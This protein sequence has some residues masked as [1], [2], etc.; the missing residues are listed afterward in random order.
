MKLA[1]DAALNSG[2]ITWNNGTMRSASVAARTISNPVTLGTGG[3]KFVAGAGEFTFTGPVT[4]AGA[5]PTFFGV[6]TGSNATF[7]DTVSESDGS[8]LVKGGGG[9]LV[10]SG[11]NSY[12]GG[13]NI[14]DGWL[15]VGADGNLGASGTSISFGS[16]GTL[17]AS[18]GTLLLTGSISNARDIVVFED[19]GSVDSNGSAVTTTGTV[20]GPGTLTKTGNGLLNVANVRTGGLDVKVGTVSVTANGGDSG[21]SQIG[22]LTINGGPGAPT[23]TFNLSD[24]D[25]IFTAT[26]QADIQSL[27][28][29]ARNGGTWGQ[30]GVNSSAAAAASPK[31]TGL[32]VLTGAEYTSVSGSGTFNGLAINSTDVLVKYTYYGDT[33]FNGTVNF[34]D[35]SRTDA[36]FNNNRS[37]WLNGD[38]DG[39]GTVNFDDYSLIDLAFNTQ[40]GTLR[41]AMTYLDG[42]DRSSSGMNEPS[43]QLVIE[44]FNQF[45]EGYANSFLNAVPEPTAHSSSLGWQDWRRADVVVGIAERRSVRFREL[46]SLL[47]QPDRSDNFFMKR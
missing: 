40:S 12:S 38:F 23:A 8:G 27:I 35:Y 11:T 16:N 17:L 7:S 5:G 3:A 15:S 6:D 28:N 43:L 4:L 45:G 29:F 18:S 1:T 46:V 44:H 19:G 13:T 41:R 47:S 20:S 10:L 26:P 34:D 2:P 24:N 33:D 14:R 30:P 36:G 22:S 9:T 31:N 42:G 21:T 25:A 32:G 39:N 37:G